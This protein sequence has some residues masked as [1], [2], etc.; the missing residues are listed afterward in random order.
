MK[1]SKLITAVFLLL[2]YIGPLIFISSYASSG[3]LTEP[4]INKDFSLSTEY[5]TSDESIL[6]F[7][8]TLPDDVLFYPDSD[9]SLVQNAWDDWDTDS[10]S[11]A[12]KY[13][14]Y[15]A[16][17]TNTTTEYDPSASGGI[18]P[19]DSFVMAWG[20]R[21]QTN[22]VNV[23]FNFTLPSVYTSLTLN[24]IM[25]GSADSNTLATSNNGS[26]DGGWYIRIWN[27]D[28]SSYVQLDYKNSGLTWGYSTALDIDNA[29]Y[30][31]NATRTVMIKYS[32]YASDLYVGIW[33]YSSS[34]TL[35][36]T[37]YTES[38][39]DVSDWIGY[40]LEA[41]DSYTT[42][43]DLLE[44]EAAN[45]GTDN[46]YDGC[47]H[48][49]STFAADNYLEIRYKSNNTVLDK[50]YVILWDAETSSGGS[51]VIDLTKS[52]SWIT[53]KVLTTI[54][55][56]FLT[57]TIKTDV[58]NNPCKLEVDY[59]R[60]GNSTN[61]GW[62]HD[63][64]TTD[65]VSDDGDEDFTYI[66]SSDGDILTLDYT[67]DLGGG[68]QWGDFLI[69][70]D[71]T[72]TPSDIETTY[73]PF[74]E[75][76]WRCTEINDG[77]V[78]LSIQGDGKKHSPLGGY[79]TSVFGWTTERINFLAETTVG[80]NSYLDFVF[81]SADAGANATIEIDY[82]KFDSIADY[83]VTQ[84]G[85]GT[86]DYLYVSDGVLYSN[87][88]DGYIEA[89]YDPALSVDTEIDGMWK[90]TTGSGTPQSDYYID[91]WAGY[92]SETEGYLASGTL[93]DFKLKF[94]DDANV[95]AITFFIAPPQWYESG[96]VEL[97][98]S[99]PID[100]TGLNMLLIFLG[101]IMMPLSTLY[102]VKGGR[103]EMSSNKLFYGIIAF[104]IG[105]ALFLGGIM[106]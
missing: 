1:R 101:L 66:S 77:M 14:D 52:T 62:Q 15:N 12:I 33:I 63:G 104:T 28:T 75:I 40:G 30:F 46:D 100:E 56:K 42:D 87:I 64:S 35:G 55:A 45:K 22:T 36:M 83:T 54:T 9:N 20:Y 21:F 94:T 84:S 23:Q 47:S 92:S 73:Y 13:N 78:Y 59:L 24:T 98:F 41:G 19:S 103:S 25:S 7:N 26:L 16:T 29:D 85:V 61:M 3:V 79:R 11:L 72:T 53:T 71:M 65:G 4:N 80:T 99:A 102:L 97:L 27:W 6:S 10:G 81:L 2:L 67:F 58:G 32:V 48:N 57:I 37:D 49:I 8:E 44:V 88:D 5:E 95:A 106:P 93:T 31:D 51:Q 74:F 76:R 89:N 68:N 86:D 96:E 70:F 18:Q 50:Y 82:A 43:G 38:F 39:A 105:W 34:I 69:P 90:L 17:K 60:L 91:A